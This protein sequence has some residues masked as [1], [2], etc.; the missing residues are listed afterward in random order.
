[1]PYSFEIKEFVEDFNSSPYQINI[2]TIS[3]LDSKFQYTS[4]N[5]FVTV[6]DANISVT[7]FLTRISGNKKDLLGYFTSDAFD[8]FTGNVSISFGDG[9]SPIDVFENIDIHSVIIP[10]DPL[11]ASLDAPMGDNDWLNSLN[12]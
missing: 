9:E 12:L 1:M 2:I 10:L 11:L 6:F 5:P 3:N 7:S 8:I 4:Q